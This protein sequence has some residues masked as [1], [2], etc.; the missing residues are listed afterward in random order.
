MKVQ[1]PTHLI[2][3]RHGESEG[4]LRRAAWKHGDTQQ[5]RIKLPE[6]EELT[7]K[8][9]EQSRQAGAWIVEHVLAQ[10][11][12][13]EFDGYFVSSSL[14]SEQSAIALDLPGALWIE[15]TCLDERDRGRI[16]GL[17]PNQ[18]KTLF[19]DS[20]GQMKRNP[21]EWVPPDGES[22]LDVA[23]RA[24]H[25]LQLV[26]NLGSVLAVTH[27]DWIWA[28]QSTIEQLSA[29]ELAE[30]DTDSIHNAHVTHYTTVK[31]KSPN[32]RSQNIWK[33]TASPPFKDGRANWVPLK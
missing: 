27:R 32:S 17:H 21:V 6:E 14:R 10:Y 2:L 24:N 19:P 15:N 5:E 22:I 31:P 7:T 11:G 20:Y 29:S 1:I 30:V 4:D 25:F 33:R 23:K 3:V 28:A 13:E 18:H 12:L 16:R 9:L 26:K 8:G